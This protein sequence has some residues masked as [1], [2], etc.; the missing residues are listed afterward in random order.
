MLLISQHYCFWPVLNKQ[1]EGGGGLGGHVQYPPSPGADVR[2][3]EGLAQCG[4]KRTR[5]E[6]GPI[7][8]DILRT[9]FMDDPYSKSSSCYFYT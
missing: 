8:A 2:R 1:T 5:G 6:E 9:S 4:Q 3:G 7:L